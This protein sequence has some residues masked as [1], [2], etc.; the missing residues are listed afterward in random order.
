VTEEA[1]FKA[2]RDDEV[3]SFY[4]FLAED[5]IDRKTAKVGPYA[6]A[7][8]PSWWLLTREAYESLVNETLDRLKANLPIDGLF[9]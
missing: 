1:A 4:P 6:T 2:R 9:F 7:H 8:A 5:S 3:F